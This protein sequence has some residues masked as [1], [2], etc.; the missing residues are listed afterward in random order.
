MFAGFDPL[1]IL[2]GKALNFA[3][4]EMHG[5]LNLDHAAAELR[6][7]RPAAGPVFPYR[8]GFVGTFEVQVGERFPS[9]A[10]WI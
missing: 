2:I 8:R 1:I 10:T 7:W 6:R 9:R 3:C 4:R 5:L